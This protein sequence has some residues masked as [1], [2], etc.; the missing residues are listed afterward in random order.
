MRGHGIGLQPADHVQHTLG[1]SVGGVNE[2]SVHTGV[3]EGHGTLPAVTEESDGG[4]D[5]QPAFVVLGGKRVL[6]GL[7]EVLGGDEALE[8]ALVVNQRKL[9]DL[10]GGE[11]VRRFLAADA[12][13]P[14]DQGHLGHDVADK[15]DGEIRF[16]H[17]AGV[18]VGDDAEEP[19]ALVDD[20]QAGDPVVRADLV[21]LGQGRFRADGQRVG[22]HAG[23]A[24]LDPVHLVGLVLDGQV[25]VDHAQAA[26][27]GHGDSHAGLGDGVHGS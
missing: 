11:L 21:E 2:Q 20:R 19:H 13:M 15:A 27:A 6:L 9:F 1:V 5:S 4:P 23:F 10:V 12:H 16:R 22:D 7:R 18:A 24:A 25:A 26:L 8:P 17:E 3:N 14:G